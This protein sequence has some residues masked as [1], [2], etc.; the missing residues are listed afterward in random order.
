MP[1]DCF[2]LRHEFL[3]R[4]SSRIFN[5]VRGASRVVKDA[6]SRPGSCSS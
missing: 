2:P 4:V 3:G 6:T 5:E 1:T